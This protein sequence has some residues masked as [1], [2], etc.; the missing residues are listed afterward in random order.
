MEF[1]IMMEQGLGSMGVEC[2][3]HAEQNW[4]HH[5]SEERNYLLSS[6]CDH[7]WWLGLKY[8]CNKFANL[9]ENRFSNRHFYLDSG[10][11]EL[12]ECML[13]DIK[14]KEMAFVVRQSYSVLGQTACMQ[15]VIFRAR[16]SET[17]MIQSCP[18][19][20]MHKNVRTITKYYAILK[21]W[22]IYAHRRLPLLVNILFIKCLIRK[23]LSVVHLQK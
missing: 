5:C 16:Q 18:Q 12:L 1:G 20:N 11:Q 4:F 3:P 10:E 6:F 14:F 17:L 7:L 8:Y 2:R 9:P 19:R 22:I 21:S 13:A 15:N 23:V